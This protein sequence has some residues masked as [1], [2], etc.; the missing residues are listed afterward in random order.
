MN[1]SYPDPRE[2]IYKKM[3]DQE[4]EIKRL[5]AIIRQRDCEITRLRKTVM[6]VAGSFA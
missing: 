1:T 5:R 2:A 4:N 6:P 3:T